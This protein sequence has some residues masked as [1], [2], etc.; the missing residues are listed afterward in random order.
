LLG[1]AIF[2]AL[3]VIGVVVVVVIVLTRA[4]GEVVAVIAAPV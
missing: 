2:D 3:D 4:A 1:V